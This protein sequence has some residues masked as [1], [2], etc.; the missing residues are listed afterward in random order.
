MVDNKECIYSEDYEADVDVSEVWYH[1]FEYGD[2]SI[3]MYEDIFN[4]LNAERDVCAEHKNSE[5]SHPI[6]RCVTEEQYIEEVEL[7]QRLHLEALE[8]TYLVKNTI[9]KKGYSN[10][11]WYIISRSIMGALS[12]E[13]MNG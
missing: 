1:A 12:K 2:G 9:K 5:R 7:T 4:A 10:R 6:R 3:D 8:M 11:H 13:R